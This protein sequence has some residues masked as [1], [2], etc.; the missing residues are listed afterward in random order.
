MK[1]IVVGNGKVGSA[2]V[3]QLSKDKHDL[4]VIDTSNE[5]IQKIAGQF[6]VLG[7]VGNGVNSEIQ[8]EAGVE[9][10]D[11]FIAATSSDE[12][13]LLCCLLAKKLGA[14]DVIARVRNPE[15]IN[16]AIFMKNEFGI[17]LII[18]PEL[19]TAKAILDIIQI[20]SAVKIESFAK[21]TVEMIEVVVNKDNPLVGLSLFDVH[22]EYQLPILI[23]AIQRDEETIIPNGNF[24]IQENDKIHL[25][26]SRQNIGKLLKETNLYKRKLNNIL[27]IGGGKTGHYLCDLLLKNHYSVKIIENDANR[28]AYLSEKF[29]KATITNGDGTNIEILKQE[30]INEADA[31]VALTGIDEENVVVAM[32]AQKIGVSKCIAKV[33]RSE[34]LQ[35]INGIETISTIAPKNVIADEVLSYVKARSNSYGNNVKTLYRLL[36][37]KADAIEFEVNTDA[38]F[39]NKPLKELELK[40]NILIASIIRDGEIILPNGNECI[41]MNDDVVVVTTNQRLENLEDILK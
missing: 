30:G 36:N 1:I 34:L 23:T 24:V 18:N 10:C 21:G 31:V 35:V 37:E 20:P 26:G 3:S 22:N 38:D 6:D 32:Y 28:C 19:D 27:I 16:Q 7:I 29:P 12:N 39:L 11:I 41:K 4:V 13:N 15:Y 33:N 40:D 2:I 25:T 14:K 8:K 17:S 5:N 9:E